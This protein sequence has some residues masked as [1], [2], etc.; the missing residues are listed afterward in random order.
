MRIRVYFAWYDLWI[1]LFVDVKKRR[2]YLC[3]LPTL[4]IELTLQPAS[5][6]VAARA[7]PTP[8]PYYRMVPNSGMLVYL[9]DEQAAP[10]LAQGKV[11]PAERHFRVDDE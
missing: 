2:L 11:W 9:S 3:L 6:W 5:D 7:D 8:R 1:G 4:V 10:L